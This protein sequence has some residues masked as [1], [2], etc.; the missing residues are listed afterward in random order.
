M[1]RLLLEFLIETRVIKRRPDLEI[2]KI[3]E[4]RFVAVGKVA[5][6]VTEHQSVSDSVQ[7]GRCSRLRYAVASCRTEEVNDA[8]DARLDGKGRVRW[9]GEV[10]VVRPDFVNERTTL[11]KCN[12]LIRIPAGGGIIPSKSAGRN[13]SLLEPPMIP[14]VCDVAV[15]SR[16]SIFTRPNTKWLRPRNAVPAMLNT[17]AAMLVA[18]RPHAQLGI[19]EEVTG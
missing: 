2:P 12:K 15:G 1:S 6:G 17:F 14:R 18:V 19:V 8:S 11:R 7:P 5:I 9:G 10:H 13:V 16:T 3:V 4:H